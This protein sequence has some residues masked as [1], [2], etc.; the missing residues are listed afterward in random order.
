MILECTALLFHWLFVRWA[1]IS[2]APSTTAFFSQRPQLFHFGN[3]VDV[4]FW[5]DPRC[6]NEE[7]PSTYAHLSVQ[8]LLNIYLCVAGKPGCQVT[9]ISFAMCKL[10]W[11]VKWL[12]HSAID[13][14]KPLYIL[15]STSK[16][17]HG[18]L[19]TFFEIL[20]ARK[21][22]TKFLKHISW[23]IWIPVYP[24]LLVIAPFY[25]DQSQSS[26]FNSQSCAKFIGDI[27][28]Y[29]CRLSLFVCNNSLKN[30]TDTTVVAKLDRS[31]QFSF[32]LW[33]RHATVCELHPAQ[34]NQC[35]NS[36]QKKT[37]C[38]N[39]SLTRSKRNV[40]YDEKIV[41]RMPDCY[42]AL[43]GNL[44]SLKISLSPE[45]LKIA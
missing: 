37:F 15:L 31:T 10:E 44:Q 1:R 43:K 17:I 5:Q 35:K 8:W 20:Q 39:V 19:C 41:S 28:N 22:F 12:K 23:L 3:N 30:S 13:S 32:Q 26:N 4:S 27:Y 34:K 24:L 40:A 38:L 14:G 25:N 45:G 7:R 2:T 18:K 9:W 42:M 16:P 11:L 29:T 21:D 6:W 36:E 33:H